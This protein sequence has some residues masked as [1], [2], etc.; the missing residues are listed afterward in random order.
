MDFGRTYGIPSSFDDAVRRRVDGVT[1][2]IDVGRVSYREWSGA[3]RRALLRERRQRRHE[4][5]GR[6]ACER[7]VEGARRQGDVLLRAHAGLLRVAEHGGDGRA[8]RRHAA[9]RP[10]ARRDRRERPVARRRD[11]ARA[12]GE[13]GRRPLRRRADRRRDEARL[14]HDRAE[15]L[16]GHVSRASEG[17]AAALARR[18]PSTRPSGCRSSSTASRSERRPAQFEIVPAALRVRVPA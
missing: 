13:A 7:H 9:R 15:D 4:R 14:H 8:R 3:R 16:Q 18:R 10:H 2:T 12:G 1:R 6:A 5:C 11:V 17:R